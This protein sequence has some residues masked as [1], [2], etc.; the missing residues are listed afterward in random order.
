MG[1]GCGAHVGRDGPLEHWKCL[2]WPIRKLEVLV[3]V[4]AANHVVGAL[5]PHG[6]SPT[7]P[8]PPLFSN[9]VGLCHVLG[10]PWDSLFND[11]SLVSSFQGLLRRPRWRGSLFSTQSNCLTG[12]W[13]DQRAFFM[14]LVYYTLPTVMLWLNRSS[15][16]AKWKAIKCKRKGR[17]E[18][19]NFFYF[20]LLARTSFILYIYI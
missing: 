8:H 6:W 17:L 18:T 19:S 15:L 10:N 12:G 16:K 20:F 3:L 11:L 14:V 9:D 4:L 5:S 13:S 2:W 1:R 7:W